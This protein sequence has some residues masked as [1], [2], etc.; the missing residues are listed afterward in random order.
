M[1]GS[2]VTEEE[3][4]EIIEKARIDRAS[5]LDLSN[6]RLA[7]LPE[8]IGSV[9]TLK[10]LCLKEN[11]L[12]ELPKSISN[13]TNL[14]NLDI[15]D[16]W[17]DRLPESIGSL[18]NLTELSL[19]DNYLEYVPES[20]G[21]LVNLTHLFLGI[22]E[23]SHLPKSIGNLNNL[24]HLFLGCNSID[25][26]PDSFNKLHNLVELDLGYN[27]LD[28][29]PR[30]IASFT[31]LVEINLEANPIDDFSI[32]QAL[33]EL[34]CAEFLGIYPPRR[35]W[36][37]L[38]DWNPKWLLDEENAEIRQVLIQQIGYDRI[39]QELDAID[40]D[41]WR[42]YTLLK[43]DADIDEEP[44][45]LLKMTCPSTRH[46]HILRVPPEMTSAEAAITWVNHGI[47]PD[48]FTVQT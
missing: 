24:T 5:E 19:E 9:C 18:T 3:L 32:L 7:R 11:K 38:S 30:N 35:Y 25:H 1:G 6:K 12:T 43:I 4:E 34:I 37:K 26:L 31:R 21:N 23:L 39:C 48:E 40:L 28:N 22:N 2:I 33:P 29:L 20:I 47:H 14:D 27:N 36:T 16:N 8:S 10:R 44:M 41:N 17:L 45:V 42:E 13:L 46:I 15:T